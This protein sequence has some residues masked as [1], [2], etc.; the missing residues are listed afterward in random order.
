MK[1]RGVRQLKMALLAGGLLVFG[2]GP[3]LASYVTEVTS[4]NPLFYWRFN[5]T[6]TG[7][8]TEQIDNSGTAV[9]SG[10]TAATMLVGQTSAPALTP[11]GGF[12]GFESGNSWFTFPA[13]NS[14]DFVAN[15]TN[16]KGEM[17]STL[18]SVSNWIKTTTGTYPTA[19]T[20]GTLYRVDQGATGAMYTFIDTTG[21][22]GLRITNLSGEAT[23]L[24]DVRSS[25]AYNDGQWHHVA[26]TWD[27]AN[28]VAV[29]YI[30]GGSLAGGETVVGVFTDGTDYVSSNR[31]QFGKGTNNASLYQGSADELAIWTS[32]LTAQQVADQYQAALPE[33]ASLLLLGLG[34]LALL[35]RRRVA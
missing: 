4:Q 5:E 34:G 24:A 6:A 3:A 29:I 20:Y 32:V 30:D 17:S 27:E 28:S 31:H 21:K 9:N 19:P 15:L 35:G 16:P 14:G 1:S 10:T 7:A 23:V 22:F 25:V 18:G 12:G 33:P 2:A 8:I 13:V 26:A 11:A